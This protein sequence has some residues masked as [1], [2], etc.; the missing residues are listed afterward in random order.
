MSDKPFHDKAL[1]IS[2]LEEL[3]GPP[4]IFHSGWGY[5]R[6]QSSSFNADT[7]QSPVLLSKHTH[8]HTYSVSLIHNLPY[9]T[10][11][12]WD[13]LFT[14]Y[15]W[16]SVRFLSFKWS[17][18]ASLFVICYIIT[19]HNA[20]RASSV[21]W[22]ITSSDRKSQFRSWRV[23]GDGVSLHHHYS[24]RKTDEKPISPLSH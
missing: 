11:N 24:E 21:K 17:Q 2:A 10:T 8:T 19:F 12:T 20:L 9:I 7:F 1:S 4:E 13:V 6:G 23:G 14:A 18:K 3:S 15:S 16:S 22:N 5:Q